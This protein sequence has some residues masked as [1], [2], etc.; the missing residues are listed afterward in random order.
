[1]KYGFSKKQLKNACEGVGIEYIHLPD[2]G[3]VSKYR[4][5]LISQKDYDDLFK[6]YRNTVLKNNDKSLNKIVKQIKINRG[7]ALTCFENNINQCHRKHISDMLFSF[8]ELEL[9]TRHI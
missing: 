3:I 2:L 4:Q 6:E 8:S 7:V 1:M 5:N 9:E